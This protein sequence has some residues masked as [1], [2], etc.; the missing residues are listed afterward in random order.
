MYGGKFKNSCQ[1]FHAISSSIPSIKA[2]VDELK[3]T[4]TN[5]RETFNKELPTILKSKNQ[6]FSMKSNVVKLEKDLKKLEHSL[7]SKSITKRDFD[8]KS[9]TVLNDITSIKK[10]LEKI[11]TSESAVLQIISAVHPKHVM[12]IVRGVYSS[13][14]L[15]LAATQNTNIGTINMGVNVGSMV[16]DRLDKTLITLSS[17]NSTQTRGWANECS[18]LLSKGIGVVLAH[19]FQMVSPIFSACVLGSQIIASVI[20][21]TV[22]KRLKAGNDN[23][24]PEGVKSKLLFTLQ[25]SL[26]AIGCATQLRSAVADQLIPAPFK[27]IVTPLLALESFLTGQI[28]K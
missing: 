9:K 10:Q 8:T 24:I 14:I 15:G 22:M 20:N 5:A 1:F 3:D 11:Q 25:T 28:S 4:F 2:S 12:E 13:L 23:K 26:V 7:R 19:K 21:K 17:L 18:A 27:A 16:H 6:L